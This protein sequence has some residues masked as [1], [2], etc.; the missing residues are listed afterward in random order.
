MSS[1]T[2]TNVTRDLSTRQSSN[3]SCGPRHGPKSVGSRLMARIKGMNEA[4]KVPQEPNINTCGVQA[5]AEFR[6]PRQEEWNWNHA[7]VQDEDS[8]VGF[9]CSTEQGKREQRSERVVR[10]TDADDEGGCRGVSDGARDDATTI[11]TTIDDQEGQTPLFHTFTFESRANSAG[12]EGYVAFRITSHEW[13]QA[14]AKVSK[15]TTVA[16][17]DINRRRQGST[18]ANVTVRRVPVRSSEGLIQP[19]PRPE[20]LPKPL[21]PLPY[22]PYPQPTRVPQRSYPIPR[23]ATRIRS[24]ATTSQGWKSQD[25]IPTAWADIC[26]N[27]DQSSRF[28]HRAFNGSLCKNHC[29]EPAFSRPKTNE[30]VVLNRPSR[31]S[32]LSRRL[33]GITLTPEQET[34]FFRKAK[35]VLKTW[36]WNTEFSQEV[37]RSLDKTFE[38]CS[39]D[40]GK[41]WNALKADCAARSGRKGISKKMGARINRICVGDRLWA[42]IDRHLARRATKAM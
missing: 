19:Q 10:H 39:G 30:F 31:T 7:A 25:G 42:V 22:P 32:S 36:G 5:A 37:L 34:I 12:T 29:K 16:R 4:H 40:K 41:E 35:K 21:R 38:T 24:P 17:N 18:S 6:T 13:R 2:N 15:R 14:V 3:G 20:D 33:S 28:K 27:R 23:P 11:N 1:F 9:A 26:G 8:G